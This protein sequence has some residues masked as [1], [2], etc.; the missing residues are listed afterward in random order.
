MR[1]LSQEPQGQISRQRIALESV[2]LLPVAPKGLLRRKDYIS[3][4][5]SSIPITEATVANR[6]PVATLLLAENAIER[7]QKQEALPLLQ[8]MRTLPPSFM[9]ECY[10]VESSNVLLA[11]QHMNTS[12]SIITARTMH[13]SLSCLIC[14]KRCAK[15]ARTKSDS[16][17]SSFQIGFCLIVQYARNSEPVS[18]VATCSLGPPSARRKTFNTAPQVSF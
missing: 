16:A 6:I 12:C 17:R 10:L 18:G 14:V 5:R 8:D 9:S 13:E 11:T 3:V 4:S 15:N 1:S 7:A 2:Q